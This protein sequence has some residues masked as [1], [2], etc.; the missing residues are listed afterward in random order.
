MASPHPFS[1]L[2]PFCP[3]MD[4]PLLGPPPRRP[5]CCST[6]VTFWVLLLSLLP[7]C[8][9]I[10]WPPPL[11]SDFLFAS[12]QLPRHAAP[13]AM[14]GGPIVTLDQSSLLS[15]PQINRS[16]SVTARENVVNHEENVTCICQ[17]RLLSLT[18]SVCF[19]RNNQFNTC[20]IC[21][22]FKYIHLS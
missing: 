19:L 11:G 18:I 4:L 3:H 10:G 9:A 12:A 14:G 16:H 15:W 1:S 6:A 17:M 7:L 8:S 2:A 21:V 22:S 13:K 5:L 20:D